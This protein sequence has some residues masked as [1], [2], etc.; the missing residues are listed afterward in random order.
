M[1]K[2][3]G[4]TVD[5]LTADTRKLRI[6]AGVLTMS[7]V[8][9]SML[10]KLKSLLPPLAPLSKGTVGAVGGATGAYI[11]AMEEQPVMGAG[12]LRLGDIA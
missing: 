6:N 4:L 11:P 3:I 12:Y 2:S 7:T 1:A 9:L 8:N 10:L 5:R